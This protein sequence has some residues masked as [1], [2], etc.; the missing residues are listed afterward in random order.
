MYWRITKDKLVDGTYITESRVGTGVGEKPEE[1]FHVRLLDDDG[2]VYY[3]G[4]ADDDGMEDM[5]YFTMNDAGCT[6]LQVDKNGEWVDE[7]A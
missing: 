5:L 6:I 3:Y 2:E 7:L 4:E 1:V